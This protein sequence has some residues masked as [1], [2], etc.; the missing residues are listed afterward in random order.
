MNLSQKFHVILKYLATC[1]TKQIY[2][3]IVVLT[4]GSFLGHPVH[5]VSIR[6]Y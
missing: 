6:T 1:R 2:G 5:F 3:L 4:W